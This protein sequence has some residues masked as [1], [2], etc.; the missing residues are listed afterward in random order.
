MSTPSDVRV[1][2]EE[3]RYVAEVDGQEAGFT[4]YRVRGGNRY[5]FPHTE[6]FE[7]WGGSGVG[8]TLVR[9]ALD[10]VRANGG[11]VIP[12][13]PFVWA[14]IQRHP[15]YGDLVDHDTFDRIADRLHES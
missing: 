8:T 11:T 7:G 2:R 10:D 13:C 3:D 4:V 5:F 15:E 6:I 1:H 9:E 14:F 12:I